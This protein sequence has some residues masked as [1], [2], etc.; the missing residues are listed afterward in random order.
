MN[1]VIKFF[2]GTDVNGGCA[3][4]Q[5]VFEYSLKKNCSMPYEIVWMKIDENP[6]SFWN[7]WNTRKWSTPFSGFRY[8][9]PEYC[10]FEGKAIYCDDDQIWLQDPLELWEMDVE[11]PF[12]MTGKRLQNGE[13][14]HCVSLWDNKKAFKHLP[15]I[16]RR[17][18]NENFCEM[19]KGLTF[20]Y[21]KII[22][23]KFNCYDGENMKIE[24]IVL[25]HLTDMSTN[26]GVH[27]AV[28]RLG[29]QSQHWY[30]GPLRSHRRDDVVSIFDQYYN[31]AIENG[32]SVADYLP[33]KRF[34]YEKQTQKNYKA[35]NGWG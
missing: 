23:D 10:N 31:E 1:D 12:I 30:D 14:R 29:D 34:S 5:M 9:I 17:K 8:G 25:L 18:D 26:P 11:N 6:E 19:M 13:I 4:C 24:E 2:V 32:F 28:K 33:N 20:P 16:S 22:D 15:P 21:T 7:G 3:E 27:K 35:N